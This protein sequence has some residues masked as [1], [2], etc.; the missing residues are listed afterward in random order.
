MIA[1]LIRHDVDLTLGTC[2]SAHRGESE[3]KFSRVTTAF[4]PY[5][6][7]CSRDKHLFMPQSMA[8]P[9]TSSPIL[10]A[11]RQIQ[12]ELA[13]GNWSAKHTQYCS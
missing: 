12:T 13:A 6:R 7:W 8:S 3:V 4:D 9:A 5:Q 1:G 11:G 10:S 2:E